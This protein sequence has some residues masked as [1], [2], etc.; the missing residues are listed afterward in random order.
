[1]VLAAALALRL[2]ATARRGS[3]ATAEGDRVAV[4]ELDVAAVGVAAVA[5]DGDATVAAVGFVVALVDRVRRR[6]VPRHHE[7]VV[8]RLAAVRRL[9][10]LVGLLDV[11][12]V[13]RLAAVAAVG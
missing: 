6:A 4:E 12:E 7:R 9:A 1:V 13:E 11:G 3:R 5:A 10:G 2:L 8:A